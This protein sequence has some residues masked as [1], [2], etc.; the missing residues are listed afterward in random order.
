MTKEYLPTSIYFLFDP[1]KSSIPQYLLFLCFFTHNTEIDLNLSP[2]PCS[3]P[4]YKN[5]VTS[6]LPPT[7]EL[8]NLIHTLNSKGQRHNQEVTLMASILPSL[9]LLS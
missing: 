1:D 7:S 9:L 3:L 5:H 8:L 2:V 6:T 4:R